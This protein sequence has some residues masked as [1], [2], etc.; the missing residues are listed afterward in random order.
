MRLRIMSIMLVA[1]AALALAA[2]GDDDDDGPSGSGTPPPPTATAAAPGDGIDVVATTTQAADMASRIARDVPGT[3]SVT[4]L[5]PAGSDPHGYELS[6]SDLRRLSD[7][8]L[9]LRHGLGLDAR[10]DDAIDGAAG[11]TVVTITS[12]IAL[13]GDDPHVWFDVE[14]AQTMAENIRD[15][16]VA[17]NPEGEAAYR[18]NAAA[19]LAELGRLHDFVRSE[20]DRVPGE[21]RKLVTDHPVLTYFAAAYDYQIIATLR[22]ADPE[23]EPSAGEIAA[24]V[25]A[26]EREHVAAV[27][28]QAGESGALV[29]RVAAEAG[30]TAVTEV[31]FDSLGPSGSGADT[32]VGMIESNTLRIVAALEGCS[33]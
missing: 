2:C 27:F 31:Y 7:A 32:F 26:I 1:A 4:A 21:C 28:G 25:E 22:P 14:R 17:A 18:A 16:L 11:A 23:G 15:A 13:L 9:V 8:E 19:Y 30:V 3:R 5:V 29:E 10:F 20:A 33:G 24:A 12:G 6:P